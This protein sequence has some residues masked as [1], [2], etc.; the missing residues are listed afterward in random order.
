MNTTK[1]TAIGILVLSSFVLAVG[2][3]SFGMTA[4]ASSHR[5]APLISGDPTTQTPL[6][7]LQTIFHLKS[8]QEVQIFTPLITMLSMK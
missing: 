3:L 8:Q 5:E 1:K 2:F 7:S 4:S 6:H